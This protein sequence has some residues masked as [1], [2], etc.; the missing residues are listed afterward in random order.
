M[1]N[2]VVEL[3]QFGGTM[4]KKILPFMIYDVILLI[5]T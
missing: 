2:L 4:A 1:Y 5:C 3:W